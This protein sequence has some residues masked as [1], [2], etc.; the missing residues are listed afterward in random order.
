[1]PPKKWSNPYIG[2][3]TGKKKKCIFLRVVFPVLGT[4]VVQ[5]EN[6]TE[7][8]VDAKDFYALIHVIS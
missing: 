4:I 1:M 2:T 6:K 8:F 3:E 7:E 5:Q